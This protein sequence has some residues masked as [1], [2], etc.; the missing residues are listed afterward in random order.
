MHKNYDTKINQLILIDRS[1]LNFEKIKIRAQNGFVFQFKYLH[2]NKRIPRENIHR[3][4]LHMRNEY[5]FYFPFE[6]LSASDR[7]S[8]YFENERVQVSYYQRGC[9]VSGCYVNQITVFLFPRVREVQER[10]TA[11]A[12]IKPLLSK[13][14]GISE[15]CSIMENYVAVVSFLSEGSMSKKFKFSRFR[16]ST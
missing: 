12:C 5:T 11:F 13:G 3:Y 15:W 9:K 14:A 6:F 1:S 2:M 4:Y 8:F 7:F 10:Q 16:M